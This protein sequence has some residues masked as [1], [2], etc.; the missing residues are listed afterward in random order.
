MRDPTPCKLC[1]Q[2][3]A[4]PGEVLERWT[5]G[6]PS[7][8]VA[9]PATVCEACGESLVASNDLARAENAVTRALID[10]GSTDPHAIRW[11]RKGAGLRA[12][13][14]AE[15]LG[16]APETVSRWEHGSRS[17]DRAA[18]A[19]LAGLALDVLDGV[20]TTRDRLR[21]LGAHPATGEVRAVA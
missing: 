8:A 12:N 19:L 11:L 20:T 3:Q 10:A 4:F 9:M 13:E 7:I 14:L 5:F 2:D 18:L 1:G 21:A 15:L 17:I 16:V 6:D